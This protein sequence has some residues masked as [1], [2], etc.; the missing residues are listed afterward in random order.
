MRRIIIATSAVLMLLAASAP[1]QA[2]PG[3]YA[4][5]GA[6]VCCPR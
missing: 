3:G 6:G 1:S 5:C 4:P 2:C